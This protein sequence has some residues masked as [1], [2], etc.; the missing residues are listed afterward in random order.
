MGRPTAFY[1]QRLHDQCPHYSD[2]ESDRFAT[3]FSEDGCLF[4]LGCVGPKTYADCPTRFWN[5]GVSMCIASGAPCVGCTEA[6][7]AAKADFPFYG[8]RARPDAGAS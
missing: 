8:E 7:F 6:F 2:Y 4:K 1:G 5:N 3:S